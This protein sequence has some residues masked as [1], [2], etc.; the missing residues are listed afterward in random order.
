[1]PEPGMVPVACRGQGHDRILA[2][3]L[4]RGSAPFE[5]LLSDARGVIRES[6]RAA[7][8]SAT[9]R[10]AARHGA[11]RAPTGCSIVLVGTSEEPGDASSFK[12]T[13][14][15]RIGAG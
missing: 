4:Q 15:R 14:V 10:D 6:Q 8:A 2:P 7:P 12:L 3:S 11:L 1:M 9:G 13:V 5:P